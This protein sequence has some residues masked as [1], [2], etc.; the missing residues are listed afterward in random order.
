LDVLEEEEEKVSESGRRRYDSPVRRERA[1]RT[2]RSIVEAGAA[3]VRE[4]QTWDWRELTFAA[5]AARASVGIR[6]VYRHFPTERDLHG[7][8]LARL[9]EESGPTYED[10][11]LDGIAGATARMHASLS[12]FA[13][14]RWTDTV[15]PQAVL[16]EVNLRRRQALLL[17]VEE[18]A[19]DWAPA[20]REMAAAVLD[21]LWG[22]PA[23]ERLRKEWNM[24]GDAATEAL[25]W[26]IGILSGAI[27]R[28]PPPGALLQVADGQAYVGELRRGRE[29]WTQL[30]DR[31]TAG[32]DAV[33][34]RGESGGGLPAAGG[35]LLDVEAFRR[36]ILVGLVNRSGNAAAGP[37]VLL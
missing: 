10:L 32:E 7:A 18:A 15:P 20:Q 3:L 24:E 28:E 5:V 11:T 4:L 16:S 6:T 8:I 19:S 27:R 25:T 23:Y 30:D 14:S 13:I 29:P 12:S 37:A 36:G 17:A 2:R 1:A 33:G 26:A 22:P 21:V 35:G 9:Q 31:L 34:V